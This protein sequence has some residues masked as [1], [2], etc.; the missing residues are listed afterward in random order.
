MNNKKR[1]IDWEQRR[2]ELI[3]EL[4]NDDFLHSTQENEKTA[5]NI[6]WIISVAD[7]IIEKLKKEEE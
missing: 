5:I 2:F 7:K 1:K 4:T 6:A 3:K